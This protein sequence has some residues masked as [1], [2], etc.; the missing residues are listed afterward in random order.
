MF[1]K[2]EPVLLLLMLNIVGEVSV[3]DHQLTTEHAL[4]DGDIYTKAGRS[5][6]M[7]E[8]VALKWRRDARQTMTYGAVT[9][10]ALANKI[11]RNT[12]SGRIAMGYCCSGTSHSGTRCSAS[13]CLIARAG[14]TTSLPQ[15]RTI[16]IAVGLL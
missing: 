9:H 15:N 2:G 4:W 12:Y 11:E 10:T 8:A 6:R 16:C 3:R 1:Q 13:V 5:S 7:P 14:L